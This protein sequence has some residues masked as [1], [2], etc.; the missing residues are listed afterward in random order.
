MTTTETR[1]VRPARR[2][3]VDVQTNLRFV[4]LR[5]V[6]R[7]VFWGWCNLSG[8]RFLPGH[9]RTTPLPETCTGASSLSPSPDDSQRREIWPM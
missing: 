5:S 2:S 1:P 8:G 3:V 4:F 7:S 6:M 9:V